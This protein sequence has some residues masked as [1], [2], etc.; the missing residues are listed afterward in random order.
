[1]PPDYT[2][3][4]KPK[5]LQILDDVSLAQVVKYYGKTPG[6]DAKSQ[7]FRDLGC[8]RRPKIDP[9]R[10]VVPFQY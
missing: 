9:L 4:T 8:W 2:T 10:A 7:L 6:Y 1:M 3:D 5:A